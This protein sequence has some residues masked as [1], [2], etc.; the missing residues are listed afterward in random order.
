M[1]ASEFIDRISVQ[2]LKMKPI[3]KKT[4]EDSSTVSKTPKFTGVEDDSKSLELSIKGEDES[5]Q[6]VAT[7][8][9]PVEDFPEKTESVHEESKSSSH[10]LIKFET[11]GVIGTK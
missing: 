2:N 7:F 11:E 5:M 6:K 9:K 4:S 10:Q 8:P 1:R 3:V